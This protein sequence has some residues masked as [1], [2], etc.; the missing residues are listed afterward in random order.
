[1]S[2]TLL[3]VRDLHTHFRT[4][5]GTVRAVDGISF[6]VQRGEVLGLV[7]ESGAGKSVAARSI[8]R[9]IDSPGVIANGE[10]RF[11]DD[12][13]V[14]VERGD[15]PDDEPRQDP[16]MLSSREIRE[17]IRG[18]EIAMIFQ[19]PTESLN[20]V[21]T[22]G[23][24][25]SEIIGLNRD[26]SAAEAEAI[27]V[28]RLREVGIPE[29]ERRM[30]DYPHEF[31]GGMRQRVLIAM[32]FACEPSLVIADEPT[33]ALDVTVEAQILDLVKDLAARYDTSFVWV[34]HDMGVVAE[35]CDRVAVMYLGEIVEQATVDD[36]FHDTK[37]PYTEALLGSIPR[38]DRDVDGLSPIEGIMPEAINPPSGCRFHT[39]CPHAREACLQVHP[40]ARLVVEGGEGDG[41]VA[42]QAGDGTAVTE[43]AAAPHRAACLRNDSFAEAGYWESVPLD[44]AAPASGSAAAE[45]DSASAD[46]AAD[47]GTGSTFDPDADPL[48]SVR[49]LRKYFDASDGFLDRLRFDRDAGLLPF[50]VDR[51]YVRAVDGVSFDILPGETLGLVGESGCGKST[52][53]RTLL[54]LVD[55]T[56]GDIVFDG[57]NLAELSK[58]ELRKRRK[59]M[60]FVFQDPQA[61]LD[62]RMTV[63]EIVEEPM[64]AHGLYEGEREARARELLETV[65]LDADHYNRYPHQFSGGQRQRVNLARALS[66][67]PDFIVC[68]EPTSALDASVQAQ[69]LN[70]MKELQDEF[71]LTYLFISHDLSV[72]RHVCD[73]VAVMYLGELV[74][75]A[76]KD[77]LF[78]SPKHPYTRALL[79]SIPVPDPRVSRETVPLSGDVPSP[80][81]PPSGCRFHTRCPSLV[82]PAELD[83]GDEEWDRVR[84]FVR[85]VQRE[86][87][88]VVADDARATYFPDG[89]PAGDAGTTVERALSLAADGAWRDAASLLTEAFVE[90]SVCTSEVPALDS[91][92]ELDRIVSCHHYS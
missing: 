32:A 33:T 27:A 63:G 88:D 70:T 41:D 22:V 67:D 81:H 75:L 73:R 47:T 61:S 28:E 7:G 68:D 35:I 74:E 45:S 64:Q 18:R 78:E 51:E 17:R 54:R 3:T 53:A 57:E 56:S 90:P 71:G 5:A 12:L 49:D 82:A 86:S 1:M 55:P 26:V 40:D 30:D 14:G 21:F 20:P 25:L 24:Q 66:V 9:L 84:R 39:R 52:L 46:D 58:E 13:L 50:S 11:E 15:D 65:G 36:L 23:E 60:Q 89:L 80:I 44:D 87:P 83:L 91:P 62:P 76:D 69:V 31:S 79:S 10:V 59:R 29:A 38:P 77:D 4:D 16:E 6:E 43:V 92:D 2:D 42:I 72:I 19:D 37:H 85:A 48:L 8:M 34:T